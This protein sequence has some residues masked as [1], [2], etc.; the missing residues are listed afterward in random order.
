[1]YPASGMWGIEAAIS[2]LEPTYRLTMFLI[3]SENP[4][5]PWIVDQVRVFGHG[6]IILAVYMENERW[7]P[8]V[9][10]LIRMQCISDESL[11]DALNHLC[12]KHPRVA[13]E[14]VVEYLVMNGATL[15][16]SAFPCYNGKNSYFQMLFKYCTFNRTIALRT[17]KAVERDVWELGYVM[18]IRSNLILPE[19]IDTKFAKK[20]MKWMI[21]NSFHLRGHAYMDVV[22]HLAAVNNCPLPARP[23]ERIFLD[24]NGF[25]C[26]LAYRTAEL[27]INQRHEN[28]C[29]M[30]TLTRLCVHRILSPDLVRRVHQAL[31]K[32]EVFA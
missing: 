9:E 6:Y 16:R 12:G 31:I 24:E 20:M 15:S 13:T 18:L 25:S 23:T 17:F 32:E 26:D 21:W 29:S 14:D 10:R 11:S 19:E 2:R 22:I 1:M 3:E 30:F 5:S 27:D 7:K 8:I 28:V 4:H